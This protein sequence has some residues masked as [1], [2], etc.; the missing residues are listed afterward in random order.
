VLK[1]TI[2]DTGAEQKLKVEGK[3]AEPWVSEL[4]LAWHQIQQARRGRRIEVD[5]SAMTFI[6]AT[7]EAALV[8]MITAGAR[9]IARGVYCEYVVRRLMKR[10]R[11]AQ[12]RPRTC[13]GARK[14]SG[15]AGKSAT[16]TD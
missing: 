4:E 15:P 13:D 10:A 16:F 12:A 7:G 3:V 14:R 9:L 2:V 1:I 8:A 5:L 6:D 11:G